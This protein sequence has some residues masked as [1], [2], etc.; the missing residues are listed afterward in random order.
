MHAP[1]QLSSIPPA[2]RWPRVLGTALAGL[3]LVLVTGSAALAAPSPPQTSSPA[4]P[5]H[6]PGSAYSRNWSGY[7]AT[8]DGFSAVHATWTVPEPAADAEAGTSATWVGIGGV[9]GDDLIQAGTGQSVSA[10][11]RV[12][13]QA[14]VETLPQAARPVAL[15]VHPGD[16]VSVSLTEQ[17]ADSWA[18]RLDNNT[19][20][21]HYEGTVAYH[22]SHSSAEWIQEAPFAGRRGI[23]PL[24]GFGTLTFSDAG[25]T[26]DGQSLNL[27]QAGARPIS[28]YGPSGQTLAVPSPL[29]PDGA[30]FS[31]ART[32]S[33]NVLPRPTVW[34]GIAS[35]PDDQGLS[36]EPG[37]VISSVVPG[38]PAARAGV[39]AGDVLTALDGQPVADLGALVVGLGDRQPGDQVVLTVSRAGQTRQLTATLQERPSGV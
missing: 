6:A 21:Q 31:V 18:V 30:S 28:M 2:S 5:A 13:Y 36:T 11:G 29:G 9:M 12:Q 39:A 7:A 26:Q 16:S 33:P 14:W 35:Q 25:A 17:E 32:T 38:G 8:G 22:S 4:A 20:G 27:A 3:L 19:T 37:L 34:L 1:R 10:S 23:L 15:A 24:N